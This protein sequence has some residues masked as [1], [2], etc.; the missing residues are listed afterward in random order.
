MEEMGEREHHRRSG[1]RG[2]RGQKPGKLERRKDERVDWWWW[3]VKVE[4][5]EREKGEGTPE[6][7]GDHCRC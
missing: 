4:E 2:G 6:G 7:A 3:W 5:R 1:G